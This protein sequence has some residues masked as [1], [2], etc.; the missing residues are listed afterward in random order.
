M[1]ILCSLQDMVFVFISMLCVYVCVMHNRCSAVLPFVT[2]LGLSF[3]ARL[4]PLARGG[5]NKK[6]G[7]APPELLPPTELLPP[8]FFLP[9]LPYPTPDQ[10]NPTKENVR[11][12]IRTSADNQ[13][14]KKA[15]K[16][17]DVWTTTVFFVRALLHTRSQ[18]PHLVVAFTILD[19]LPGCGCCFLET[20]VITVTLARRSGNDR[21][22][23]LP[24]SIVSE[25][26]IRRTPSAPRAHPE[27]TPSTPRAHP[28]RTPSAPRA[29]PERTTHCC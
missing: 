19:E 4:L 23:W 18:A 16:H 26:W 27:R 11:K 10:Q 22:P 21:P 13:A 25:P 14:T 28:E 29:H 20:R 1:L 7:G 9:S 2:P 15:P 24:L 12:I 17:V 3:L 8:S 5:Q 6:L